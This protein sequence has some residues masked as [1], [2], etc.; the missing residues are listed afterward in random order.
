MSEK[1]QIVERMGEL[2]TAVNRLHSDAEKR[3][4]QQAFDRV[5]TVLV[6]SGSVN[7]LPLPPVVE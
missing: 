3:A 7:V 1:D 4:V 2:Q 6:D 5:A